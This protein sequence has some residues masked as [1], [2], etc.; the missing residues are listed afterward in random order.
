MR[1]QKL[2][3]PEFLCSQFL[4][5]RSRIPYFLHPRVQKSQKKQDKHD[6]YHMCM[7]ITQHK[8]VAREFMN[9]LIRYIRVES[10]I[11]G[12]IREPVTVYFLPL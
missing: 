7:K 11:T 12:C 10:D 6:I 5:R 4:H 8:G 2:L 1:H 9:G 3:H